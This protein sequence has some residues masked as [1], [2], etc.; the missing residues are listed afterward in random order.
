MIE[1]EVIPAVQVRP[2]SADGRRL[3]SPAT[4]SRGPLRVSMLPAHDPLLEAAWSEFVSGHFR[5]M[6]FHTIGWRNAVHRTFAHRPFY[7]AAQ[8][9]ERL[10][11]VMPL[12]VVASRLAGRMLVS[13][14]YG[15]G[16]GILAEDDETTMALFEAARKLAHEHRCR[17]IDL[18]NHSSVVPELPVVR[19]YVGF[20]RELPERVEDV[21]AWL[22]RKARAAARNGEH[23]HGLTMQWE[24]ALL[25]EVWRLYALSMRRLGSIA[26]PFRFF[27]QLTTNLEG[28]YWVCVVRR[29]TSAV[30]GLVTLLH[31]DTVMPYYVGLSDDAPRYGAANFLYR[32]VMERAVSEGYRVFDFGRTRVDNHGS[33]DFKRFHGFEPRPL[34]YQ[35]YV[36]AGQSPPQLSPSA[37]RYRLARRI[38]K[39]LPLGVTQV[40][41]SVLAPHLPG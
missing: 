39:H 3:R 38:W 20:R 27:E 23:K 32:C 37:R 25:P 18:R 36:C 5:G 1:N 13:V 26:Y 28:G 8:R 16:G 4:A 19:R 21:A 9:G 22:P 14:P 29:G 33:L 2:R 30:A 31:G 34:P 7:L 11:G 17:C 12:F 41:S 6:V 35:M 10:T 15:V 40:L 24:A